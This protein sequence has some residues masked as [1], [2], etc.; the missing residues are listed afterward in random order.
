M[1]GVDSF[2][3]GLAI[4]YLA[5]FFAM[6]LFL[7]EAKLRFGEEKAFGTVPFLLLYPVAFFL[8]AVYTESLFLLL[9]LLSF[10]DVRN[11]Q[12]GRAAL[13]AFLAGLTRAPA[14]ALGPPL[15]LAWVAL[16]REKPRRLATAA[17]LLL[18]P[19]AGVCLWIFGIGLA[20]GEPYLFF[21]SM[22]AWR[23]E[24]GHPTA[25]AFAFFEELSRYVSTG[26]FREHPGALL[27]YL[28]F[29]LFSIVTVYLLVKRRLADA[30]W[31][32]GVLAL[33][34]LTGTSAGVPRYTSTIYVGHFALFSMT[35]GRPL[36][37]RALLAAYTAVLLLNTAFFVNWHFVS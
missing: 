7:E 6:P 18:A 32:A 33:S 31:P 17:A 13:W 25:G 23:H 16:H 35:E 36:L 21:R 27:P 28:H 26:Y 24:A 3:C 15:A 2:Q 8:A 19:V 4:T 37:R 5:L 1:T 34:V 14:A 20:K 30:S 29:V 22:G 12:A 11:G 10:R 9:A